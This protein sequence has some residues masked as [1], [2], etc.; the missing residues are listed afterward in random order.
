MPVRDDRSKAVN[1]RTGD[2]PSV[3]SALDNDTLLI[4]ALLAG[5][6]SK[7]IFLF[8]MFLRLCSL[9]FFMF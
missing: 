8:S 7:S 5:T 4:I 1:Q 6:S 2:F 9:V 3:V